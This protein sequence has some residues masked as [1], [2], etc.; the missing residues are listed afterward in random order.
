VKF[1]TS[2]RVISSTSI[3][4]RQIQTREAIFQSCLPM[5]HKANRGMRQRHVELSRR[6][7]ANNRPRI[8]DRVNPLLAFSTSAKAIPGSRRTEE[9]AALPK[10][11][12]W[13]GFR[14]TS[15][16]GKRPVPRCHAAGP[17]EGDRLPPGD[18]DRLAKSLHISRTVLQAPGRSLAAAPIPAPDRIPS[19]RTRSPSG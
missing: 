17:V 19:S 6:A 15:G 11:Y 3:A 4:G 12:P 5:H 2:G 14:G 10:R 9:V 16:L 13:W 7:Q 18:T 8:K 1:L